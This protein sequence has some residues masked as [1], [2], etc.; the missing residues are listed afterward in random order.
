[1]QMEIGFN[2]LYL[3]L[4]WGLVV[5]MRLRFDR[6]RPED[7]Q[8]ANIFWL[9]FFALAFGDSFHVGARTAAYFMPGGLNASIRVFGAIVPVV[10][11]SSLVTAVTITIFYLFFLVAWIVRAPKGFSPAV[12]SLFTIAGIR[13][14]LLV[15]PENQWHQPVP[16]Q[17]W[18]IIRNLPLILLGLGVAALFLI[19]DFKEDRSPFR[20]L[21]VLILISYA[22]YIPVV[23]YIQ[24]FPLLGLLMIP[25]TMA[26]L[27]MAALVYMVLYHESSAQVQGAV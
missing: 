20:W 12:Y 23:F 8:L 22:T 10:G 26:Y 3:S 6:V 11:W 15:L 5:V 16:V 4:I 1:M 2:L 25:K 27:V 18:A 9:A 21:G 7:R 19:T 14:G 17:P 13:L 24:N